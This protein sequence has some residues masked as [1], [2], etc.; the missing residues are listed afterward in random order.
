MEPPGTEFK[1]MECYTL[2]IML[3]LDI[4]NL[5]EAIN[6]SDLRKGGMAACTGRIIQGTRGY[7]K[8]SIN[9]TFFYDSWFIGN[10]KLDE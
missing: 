2:G 10:K 6:T 7:R 4:Q 5:K 1:N 8:V 9:N 3:Y